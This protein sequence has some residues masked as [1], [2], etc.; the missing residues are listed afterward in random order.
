MKEPSN[1]WLAL[2]ITLLLTGLVLLLLAPLPA[3]L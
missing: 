3:G 2:G 1:F